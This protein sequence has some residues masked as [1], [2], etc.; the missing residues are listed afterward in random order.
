MGPV[1]AFMA[2]EDEVH[3]L[4]EAFG[5]NAIASPDDDLPLEEV[6]VCVYSTDG[7]AF[8]ADKTYMALWQVTLD[9]LLEAPDGGGSSGGIAAW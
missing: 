5:D 9:M 8:A 6:A 3:E 7:L 1:T 2:S 4:I